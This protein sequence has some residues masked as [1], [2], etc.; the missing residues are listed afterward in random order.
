MTDLQT[1]IDQLEARGVEA[2]LLGYLAC[3]SD[4][5]VR[6]RRLADELR[7][8]AEKLRRQTLVARAA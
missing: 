1:Q 5:R 8:E 3:D 6:N 2:E 4:T 7:Q